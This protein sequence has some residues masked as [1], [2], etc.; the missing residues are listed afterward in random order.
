MLKN[1]LSILLA[2]TLLFAC[3]GGG[4]GKY[5]QPPPPARL[6]NSNL[7]SSER[8]VN[9][10]QTHA[11]GGPW[12]GCCGT[13]SHSPGLV[14]FNTPP[15]V[16]FAT[17]MS[18]RERVAS[19]YAVSLINRALPYD[20]HLRLGLDAPA[21][22]SWDWRGGLPDIPDGQIFIEFVNGNPRGGPSGSTGVAHSD[23]ILEY[24]TQQERW[25]KKGRRAAAVEINSIFFRDRPDW[26]VVSV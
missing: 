16:R 18:E 7:P 19:M 23:T 14:R 5:P 15:T 8:I 24:D 21:G 12:E 25:E 2:T 26:Q 9:Y 4:S 6:G 22:V 11:S 10:L 20:Q 13:Y 1:I 17:G 3:G